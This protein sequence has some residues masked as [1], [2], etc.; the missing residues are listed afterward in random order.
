MSSHT[1]N[2]PALNGIAF[3]DKEL[4]EH[5]KKILSIILEDKTNNPS[6]HD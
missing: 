6:E 1:V 5:D 3:F 4:L 2:S